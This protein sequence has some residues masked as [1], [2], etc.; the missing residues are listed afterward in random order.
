MPIVFVHADTVEFRSAAEG[1]DDVERRLGRRLSEIEES[2]GA[3]AI[4]DSVETR[5]HL[6]GSDS[7]PQLFEPR[8]PPNVRVDSHAHIEDE[9][10]HVLEGEIRFGN[11]SFPAGSTIYIPGGTLYS[12][13]SGPDGV[14][15]LNFRRRADFSV[16]SKEQVA[17]G[18]E[19]RRGVD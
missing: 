6:A 8:F 5:M 7:E 14:R 12:F 13:T 19:R 1:A 16:L 3:G 9:V 2:Q 17:R 11:R 10:M 15:F 18:L 4:P